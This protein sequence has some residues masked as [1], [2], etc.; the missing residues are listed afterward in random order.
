MNFLKDEGSNYKKNEIKKM[1]LPYLLYALALV[2]KKGL[3]FQVTNFYTFVQ[4]YS[5]CFLLSTHYYLKQR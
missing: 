4:F 1:I 2:V 5:P 3:G